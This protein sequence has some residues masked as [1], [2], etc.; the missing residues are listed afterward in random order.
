MLICDWII[1]LL[2]FVNTL[3]FYLMRQ[4]LFVN[5]INCCHVKSEDFFTDRDIPSR[6]PG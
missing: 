6:Q 2:Y 1:N 5:S 3:N 4:E